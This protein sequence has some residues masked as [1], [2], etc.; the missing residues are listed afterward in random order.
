MRTNSRRLDNAPL[1]GGR[2]GE[3]LKKQSLRPDKSKSEGDQLATFD[4][5][6][7]ATPEL[8]E[9]VAKKLAD[10]LDRYSIPVLKEICNANLLSVFSLD[11]ISGK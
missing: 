7:E 1:V 4:S 9:H 6:L 10:A 3:T 5:A 2:L 8:R 11:M